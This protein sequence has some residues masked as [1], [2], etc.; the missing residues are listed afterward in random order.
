MPDFNTDT[1]G[2]VTAYPLTW[3]YGWKRTGPADRQRAAFANHSMLRA[4]GEVISQVRLMAGDNLIISTNVQLRVDG[5]PY[6]DRRPPTDPGAAVYFDF[7]GRPVVF[8]CDKWTRVEHNL[9]AIAR[10]IENLRASDRYGVGELEQAFAGYG[11]IAA[12]AAIEWW[13]VLGVDLFAEVDEIKAAYRALARKLHPD[14]GGDAEAFRVI[15][16]AYD[17]ARRVRG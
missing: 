7:N 6:S 16:A 15:Q 12:P 5:L 2:N 17:E 3:P 4:S 13:T 8:A 11:Q 1:R 9:W 10:H 14:A